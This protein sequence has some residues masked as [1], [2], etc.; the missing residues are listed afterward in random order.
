MKLILQPDPFAI[1]D[2][3]GE[4]TRGSRPIYIFP[5]GEIGLMY[6][7]GATG[8]VHHQYILRSGALIRQPAG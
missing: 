7:I 2:G 3:E 4:S 8:V 5:D 6:R 1:M